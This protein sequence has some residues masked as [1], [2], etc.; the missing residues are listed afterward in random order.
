MLHA[1][2]SIW[3]I[4]CQQTKAGTW[5]CFMVQ[6]LWRLPASAKQRWQKVTVIS[7]LDRYRND[8]EVNKSV[9]HPTEGWVRSTRK[10][11]VTIRGFVTLFFNVNPCILV[12]D[13][14]NHILLVIIKKKKAQQNKIVG[15]RGW[16]DYTVTCMHHGHF[17]NPLS[18][19]LTKHGP[20]NDI[21]ELLSF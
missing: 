9:S 4:I 14:Y 12:K 8:T 3:G 2:I 11:I 5:R 20:Y 16:L 21:M 1:L 7:W 17:G 15:N 6:H 10:T 18:H 13:I 19:T